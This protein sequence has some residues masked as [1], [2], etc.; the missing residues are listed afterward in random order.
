MRK[1]E[2][3]SIPTELKALDQWVCWKYVERDGKPTK[4]PVNPRTG[5]PASS[6]DPFTWASFDK[7]VEVYEGGLG[8]GIGFV[9][10][11]G[12]PFVGIDLDK[13]RDPETG[14]VEPWA[15]EIVDSQCSYSEVTVSGLGLRV[16]DKA[17]LPPSGRKKGNIEMY[18]R[19]RF[20][21]ITGKHLEGTPQTIEDRHVQ[22]SKLHSDV[23]GNR[24]K[25]KPGN[26]VAIGTYP[27]SDNE[28][29]ERANRATNGEKFEQLWNGIWEEQYPSQ[30]EAELALCNFLLFHTKGDTGRTDA[31][32]RQSG[33]MRQ[34]WDEPRGDRTYGQMTI[35]KALDGGS[36]A[37]SSPGKAVQEARGHVEH[38]LA[39]DDPT[40][41]IFGNQEA[42]DSLALVKRTDLSEWAVMKGNLKGKVNLNDLE[43]A[44][45]RACLRLVTEEERSERIPSLREDESGYYKLKQSQQGIERIVLSNFKLLARER[46][47]MPDGREVLSVDLVVNGGQPRRLD[48]DHHAFI[49]WR[50]LLS[51]LPTS[52]AVWLGNDKDV[53]LLR[54]HLLRKDVLRRAGV[55]VMGRHNEHIVMPGGLVISKDGVEEDPP[56]SLVRFAAAQPTRWS[57]S[58][59]LDDEPHLEA[60]ALIYEHLPRVNEAKVVM[61]LISWFFALP[62]ALSIK[63]APCWGGFPHLVLW[64]PTGT[65]KT[66]YCE[67]LMGLC[68]MPVS[69]EPFSLPGTRYT[70]LEKY[71]TTNLVP[72]FF[73][74]YRLGSMR[75][76]DIA[77]IHHEL[78]GLYGGETDERGRP[79][80]TVES[81][82]LLAPI[83]LAGEDRPRDPALDHRMLVIQPSSS[84]IQGNPA[85]KDAYNALGLAPLEL[86]SP[87]YWSWALG[88]E[89]WLED[90]ESAREQ[91]V[92]CESLEG[93]EPP[94][95]IV[96]N[97][98]IVRF[99]WEAFLRY[100][101]H[102]GLE[103]APFV[104]GDFDGAMKAALDQVMP[105][106]RTISTFD[107]LMIFIAMMVNN[108]RLSPGVHFTMQGWDRIVLRLREAHAEA[109]KY[110]REVSKEGGLLGYDH[111]YGLAKE[112]ASE[113]GS[114]VLAW[115]HP[116]DFEREGEKRRQLRGILIDID[117]LERRLGIDTDT[118]REGGSSGFEFDPEPR[119]GAPRDGRDWDVTGGVTPENTLP[120][121]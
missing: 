88:R 58:S 18:D 37:I 62:W 27:L 97:L 4:L 93:V 16:W 98:A 2:Y 42:I 105:D 40:K 70:R 107:D 101:E 22:L 100:G 81:Y 96:N 71:S 59:W 79:N 39:S 99:G 84:V 114:Y 111:Y 28:V 94:N 64:G 43:S 72:V 29:I 33:L 75:E 85:C 17:E 118:W 24:E 80:L 26:Q 102:L 5:G 21:T 50:D 92:N 66:T 116:A 69:A 46:L 48:L 44:T 51:H 23:F 38:A 57:Q 87:R 115:S 119:E 47:T 13:C 55:K 82:E 20:F 108:G 9:V 34:K 56:I 32:F 90:L 61:P 49:G 60:A 65:G 7:A 30:S 106:G 35:E 112:M 110:S 15:L 67:L 103:P 1:I 95:R 54:A 36:G 120:M 25:N 45:K 52:E 73:D 76:S 8:D 78:R 31:L 89:R 12:D 6:T 11:G 109:R 91:M 10:T 117:E 41:A 63:R 14:E 77:S 113:E 19:A 86:F 68:G 104:D 83:V 74:E 3:E 121:L 53:Q